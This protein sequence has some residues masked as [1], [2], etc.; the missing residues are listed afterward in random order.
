MCVQSCLVDPLSVRSALLTPSYHTRGH[1]RIVR[2]FF[3][4]LAIAQPI[5]FPQHPRTNCIKAA[6]NMWVPSFENIG[7]SLEIMDLDQSF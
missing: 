2:V 1:A 6:Y 7:L 3:S 5:A 4:M